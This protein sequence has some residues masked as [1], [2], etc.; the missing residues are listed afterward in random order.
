MC[1]GEEGTN[2]HA[3]LFL[4]NFSAQSLHAYHY[5]GAHPTSKLGANAEQQNLSLSSKWG[6]E[7]RKD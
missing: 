3:L 6:N 5:G 1:A 2:L 7:E 4:S